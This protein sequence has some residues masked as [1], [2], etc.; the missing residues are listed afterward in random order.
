MKASLRQQVEVCIE[1]MKLFHKGVLLMDEVDLILHPLKSEL[2][3][4][5]GRKEPLDLTKN[6]LGNGLRWELPFFL[7]DAVFYAT[8]RQFPQHA[9]MSSQEAQV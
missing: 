7:L 5:V 6:K 2:N 4:P 3:F 9:V 8:E 1:T